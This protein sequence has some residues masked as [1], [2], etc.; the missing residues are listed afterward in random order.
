MS[1]TRSD[2]GLPPLKNL[3]RI[4]DARGMTRAQLTRRQLA[5]GSETT[6]MSWCALQ[7]WTLSRGVVT[8]CSV[9]YLT[10]S[11]RDREPRSFLP[12][13]LPQRL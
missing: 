6:V 12:S 13:P 8:G 9:C 7:Q 2:Y 11:R 5:F 4:L 10:G 3:Q 1:T